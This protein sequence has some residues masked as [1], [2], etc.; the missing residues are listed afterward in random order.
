MALLVAMPTTRGGMPR[1]RLGQVDL[2][3]R[4]T[5][6]AIPRWLLA[7]GV[8]FAAV[9]GGRLVVVA[10]LLIALGAWWIDRRALVRRQ[11]L[12]VALSADVVDAAA[13]LAA[14]LSA[15]RP[16][17][18][19][20]ESLVLEHRAAHG[21]PSAVRLSERLAGVLA[22]GQL[23]GDVPA[24]WRAAANLPGGQGLLAVGA[25]WSVAESTGAGLVDVLDPVVEGLR[26]QAAARRSIDVALAGTRA[27]ASLLA[28]L[29][30]IGLAM[31]AG[32]GAAPIDFLLDTAFGRGC[33]VVGFG[34]ELIGLTWTER[35]A[36]SARRAS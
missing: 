28:G 12:A 4:W 35:L 29:P 14:D 25:A 33:L 22:T 17:L 31:G 21:S 8:A 7:P 26:E 15:G 32:L 10:A 19:A 16:P 18:A 3:T 1:L 24:A 23:G 5:A 11:R 13:A 27:T 20:L 2:R 6:G 30:L 9:V 36:E 34:L